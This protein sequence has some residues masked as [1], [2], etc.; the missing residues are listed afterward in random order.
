MLEIQGKLISLDLLEKNF[1]CN[2]TACKG[3]CCVEGEQGAPL[4]KNETGT[5]ARIAPA[6][7]NLLESEARRILEKNTHV[8]N[9]DGSISTPLRADRSCAYSIRDTSGILT[10][11]IEKAFREGL[12]DWIKPLSCH[13]YPIRVNRNEVTGWEALNYDKWEICTPA[14]KQGDWLGIPV[15]RF[16]KDALVRKFGPDFYRELDEVAQSWKENQKI[17]SNDSYV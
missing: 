15:Y 5:L 10:C 12:I 6:V 9:E 2:L 14:C 11:G 16:V 17:Q 7:A 8:N 1:S 3:A 13:L 4:E